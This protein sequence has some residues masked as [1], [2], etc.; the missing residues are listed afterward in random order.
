MDRT[1]CRFP[2]LFREEKEEFE[3]HC[4]MAEKQHQEHIPTSTTLSLTND[5]TQSSNLF[6]F[7]SFNQSKC[8]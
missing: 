1:E 6:L 2:S 3:Q 8:L 4:E 7:S 5:N